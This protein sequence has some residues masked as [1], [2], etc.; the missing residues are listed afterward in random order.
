MKGLPEDARDREPAIPWRRIAGTRD[1]LIHDYYL[2]DLELVWE[3]VTHHLR[4]LRTAAR[5]LLQHYDT[6]ASDGS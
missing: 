3:M 6:D 1:K 2:V 5:A 4:P